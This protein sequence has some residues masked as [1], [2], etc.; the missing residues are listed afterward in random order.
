MD[1]KLIEL[2]DRGTFIPMVALKFNAHTRQELWL[3]ARAGF[4]LTYIDQNNYVLFGRLDCE[5]GMKCDPYKWGN[6]RTYGD[7]H[8]WLLANWDEVQSGDVIDVEYIKGE[9]ETAKTSERVT[10]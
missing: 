3:A 2:R 7:A 4:G 1:I 10:P 6:Q 5:V 8:R 9:T